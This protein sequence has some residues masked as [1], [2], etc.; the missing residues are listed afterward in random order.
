MDYAKVTDAVN[1]LLKTAAPEG[2]TT[3]DYD[4]LPGVDAQRDLVV[5]HLKSTYTTETGEML[6]AKEVVDS[7][8]TY[9]HMMD[10]STDELGNTRA[11]I[12]TLTEKI[13]TTQTD[14]EK[15]Q[16]IKNV[17]QIL[18]VTVVI[19]IGVYIGMG[20]WGHTPAFFVLLAGFM[21]VLHTRGEPVRLDSSAK[22][23]DIR[24]WM[25]TTL[26]LWPTSKSSRSQDTSA[27]TSTK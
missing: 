21:Y 22:F 27:P 6:N 17:L 26:D 11:K 9:K 15:A 16:K 23:P 12:R 1:I 7:A 4:K 2:G 18:T 20:S 5:S 10:S 13:A 3:K 14:L 19:T 25:Y 8:N 24:Q